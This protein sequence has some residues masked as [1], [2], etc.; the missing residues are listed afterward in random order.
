MIPDV[1]S[2]GLGGRARRR[3]RG[4]AAAEHEQRARRLR[5][6][7]HDGHPIYVAGPQVGY[8]YPAFFLEIDLHGG[9]FDARGVSFP[10]VPWIVIGRG[11]DYAWSATTSHSDIVDQYVETLCFGDDT[12]YLYKGVCHGDGLVR[13]RR[14]SRA[15][16]PRAE[17][18][19]DRT[20]AGARLRDRAAARRSRSRRSAPRAGARS[21]SALAFDDLDKGRVH[22]A[23]E[24]RAS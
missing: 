9:G 23:K 1:G 6:A 10:G 8:F 20:R 3:G 13:R 21:L 15:A 5:Q 7:F 24:L 11:P 19:H 16:R 18:P 22:S 12:H 14:R 4:G 17:L 2:V